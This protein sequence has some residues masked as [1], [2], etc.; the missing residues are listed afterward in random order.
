MRAQ[1]YLKSDTM[2]GLSGPYDT[3]E[4]AWAV[5]FGGPSTLADRKAMREEGWSVGTGL[6]EHK[7]CG[8][9]WCFL[10]EAA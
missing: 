2:V 10:Q 5:V 6:I 8:C 7:T 1:F 9:G 3:E 4:A